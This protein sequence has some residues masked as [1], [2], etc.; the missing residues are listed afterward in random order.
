MLTSATLTRPGFDNEEFERAFAAAD[1][2]RCRE[3]LASSDGIDVVL[4]EAR[5]ALRERRYVDIIGSLSDLPKTSA[6]TRI[7]RDVLLGAA[8]G[9]TRD[10]VA[11]RRLIERALRDL[12]PGD[13]WRD[14]ALYYKALIAWMR[15]EN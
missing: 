3:L 13:P 11:G 6:D 8:L 14:E 9:L 2:E 5:L 12:N 10:Y 7:A 1:F 4:A 15:Q